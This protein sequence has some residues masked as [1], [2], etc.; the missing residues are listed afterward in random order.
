MNNNKV[1]RNPELAPSSYYFSFYDDNGDRTFYSRMFSGQCRADIKN[2]NR[3]RRRCVIG[4]EFCHSHL[5]TEMKLQIRD[6]EYGLGLFAYDPTAEDNE[7]VF[8]KGDKVCNYEGEILSQQEL[9]DRYAL[10]TAPYGMTV[11]ANRK[12]DSALRR[13][14]GSMINH[15]TT[16]Q[17]RNV[18]FILDNR[19]QT[20]SLRATKNIRQNA[21]LYVSY[22]DNYNFDENFQTR[23]YPTLY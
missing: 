4:I 17:Q 5:P 15:G 14:I 19:R 10:N 2:G 11:S 23:K 7:I 1:N 21:Q 9:T 20:I 3:C 16:Q 8:R 12:I 18:A 22:G 6:S 13:G